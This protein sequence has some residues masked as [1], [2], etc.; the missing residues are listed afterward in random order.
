MIKAFLTR[1]P[2]FTEELEDGGREAI[3]ATLKATESELE[4]GIWGELFEEG[5]FFLAADKL[6]RTRLGEQMREPNN[7][8]SKSAYA[9]E[10]ERLCKIVSMGARVI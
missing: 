1:F 4:K 3:L 10:F 9:V 2:E 8:T 6:F 7:P 5:V